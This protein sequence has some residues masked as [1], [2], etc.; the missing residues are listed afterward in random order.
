MSA[1]I[2]ETR[3]LRKVYPAESR[4]LLRFG[5]QKSQGSSPVAL[6][7]LTTTISEGE[8]VGLI[9]ANGAGKSTAVKLLAGIL[10]PTSGSVRIFGKDPT[11]ERG[12]NAYRFGIVMGQ[13]S[14]LWW[15]LPAIDSLELYRRMYGLSQK[16]FTLVFDIFADLLDLREFVGK[17]VRKLSLGQRMRCEL[18]AALLHRPR[19]LFLDEPTIGIDVLAK[20][21]IVEFLRRVNVEWQATILLTTHNLA[22]MER[23]ADRVLIL[24]RGALIYDDTINQL[25]RLETER[26]IEVEF[27]EPVDM[28]SIPHARVEQHGDLKASVVFE[29]SRVSTSDILSF[30]VLRYPVADISVAQPHIDDLVSKIY[31]RKLTP[32][33]DS[34]IK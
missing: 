16:D 14:Q 34:G 9:G 4:G 2:I 27:K 22:D 3:E 6:A 25:R 26:R 18:A 19:V 11:K 8:V 20:G 10:S 33:N 23:I 5:H 28:L 24:D 15:D 1:Q 30:I 32:L 13:R 7:G 12:K 17:P 29:P 21:K 31:A